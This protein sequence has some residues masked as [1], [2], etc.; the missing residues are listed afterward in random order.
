MNQKL[1]GIFL[2]PGKNNENPEDEI[3][4]SELLAPDTPEIKE[5]K[6][7]YEREYEYNDYL[8]EIEFAIAA[9]YNEMNRNL[10]D[11][12]VTAALKNIKQNRDKP[13]GFYE[14]ELEIS[15][16]ASLIEPLEEKPL[17]NHEFTLV[18]D[19]VLWAI[20]NMSWIEDEQA[21]VKWLTYVLGFFSDM[22]EE[23][24]ERELKEYASNLGLPSAQV[25]MLL[26]RRDAEDFFEEGDFFEGIENKA[27]FFDKH[28]IADDLE[29]GFFLMTDDEKFNFLLDKGPDY[30]ELVLD[31]VSYLR[32]KED[33][34]KI[35]D[36]YKKSIEKH[37]GF[38]PL[39]FVIGTAY[40]DK[41]P[42]LAK[43]YF[44]EAIRTAEKLEEIPE[45]TKKA[46]REDL[47]TLTKLLK[48][49]SAEEPK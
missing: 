18:F 33:F 49:K 21:Y 7:I 39:Q 30:F 12:D 2:G 5:I 48:K 31:Y 41:N 13:I 37:K 29:T 43:S 32:N 36:F 14:N 19:Y 1:E 10:K 22:E 17:T 27:E 4:L 11:K 46:L 44:E 40:I 16:A 47:N 8:D 9:F 25:D 23:K 28:R 3:S 34:E 24:Y 35:Q 26:M 42:A 6:S 38:F 20:E 45:E 15:I